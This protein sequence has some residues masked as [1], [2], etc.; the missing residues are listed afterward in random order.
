[1]PSMDKL[2]ITEADVLKLLKNLNPG[3]APGP[4][5]TSP[6]VLKELCEVI[7]NPL[8]RIFRKSLSTGQVPEA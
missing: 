8:T 5:N 7:A 3:K 1:M 2:V 6:R 4:D